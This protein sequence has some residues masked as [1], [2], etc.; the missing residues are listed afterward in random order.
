MIAVE[1][2]KEG[3]LPLDADP[4]TQRLYDIL[5]L[6]K[7]YQDKG[8]IKE[9]RKNWPLF[10]L[11]LSTF[12]ATGIGNN[13]E[14]LEAALI[15]SD[16]SDEVAELI[17]KK[18]FTTSFINLYKKF[19]YDLSEIRGNAVKFAQYII[20]P[21]LQADTNKLAVGALWKLLACSGGVK[22]LV[23]KGF[24]SAA[25]KPEDI[26]YLLQLTCIRNCSMLLQYAAQGKDMFIEQ[27]NVQA[28]LLTLSDFDG[29]RGPERRADGFAIE[30]GVNRNIY[31]SMLNEGV[32][33]IHAPDDIA[34]SLLNAD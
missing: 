25:I 31:N 32:K 23:E 34:D 13:R 17:N 33:L 18:G 26:S 14:V 27:P 12:E 21:L 8:K 7:Q 16:N 22:L 20:I 5:M 19:F 10:S 6:R 29:I 28:F 30:R 9:F 4:W 24:R 11:L 3:D 15:A 1:A 2:V